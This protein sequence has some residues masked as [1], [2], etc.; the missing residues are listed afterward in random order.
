MLR[1][2][3]LTNL[4]NPKVV[5]FFAAFL[6]QFV[7]RG[8]GPVAA[9]FLTLGLIF[10][11][12]GLVSDSIIGLSLGRLGAAARPVR[13]AAKVVNIGAALTFAGLAAVMMV[14]AVRPLAR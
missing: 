3:I 11:V 14:E 1:R 10:L 7:R 13:R 9:Q 2:A 8:H 6:P 4:T 5:L 12:I